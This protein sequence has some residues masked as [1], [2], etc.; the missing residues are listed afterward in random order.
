MRDLLNTCSVNVHEVDL[1]PACSVRL[2]REMSSVGSPGRALIVSGAIGQLHD[3]TRSDIHEEDVEAG[4]L[5]RSPGE[6]Q[7]S[8]VGRPRRGIGK[9][10]AIE[11]AAEIGP[12]GIY[13]IDL[14]R[15]APVRNEGDLSPCPWVPSR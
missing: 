11:D 3:L 15:S 12:I 2:K 6:G 7:E 5:W 8:A 9:A 1:E 4:R 14:R 10:P 13:D